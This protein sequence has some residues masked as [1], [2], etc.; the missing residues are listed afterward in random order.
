MSAGCRRSP[1]AKHNMT[2]AH[3]MPDENK[4]YVRTEYHRE[5]TGVRFRTHGMWGSPTHN[6]WIHMIQRCTN[7]NRKCYKNYGAKGVTVC[8]RWHD[9]FENFL[10][11]M[12]IRPVGKTLDRI[13]RKGNYCKENCKWETDKGQARNKSTNHIVT[14]G[15][16]TGCLVEA[17]EHFGVVEH[18]H[19]I[20]AR[21]NKLGWLPEKAILTPIHPKQ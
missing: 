4:P 17:C 12:G 21:I 20:K 15:D 5:L 9:S 10:E 14:V 16:F 1:I 3:V 11:D 19:S 8:Q 13:D 7:P 2:K 6:T 18:Y